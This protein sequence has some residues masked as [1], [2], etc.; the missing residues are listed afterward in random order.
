MREKIG[1]VIAQITG[2]SVDEIMEGSEL[3]SLAGWDSFSHINI[4]L[5]IEEE[6][7]L[8]LD[9]EDLLKMNSFTSIIETVESKIQS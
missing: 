6:F 7:S 2:H 3:G 5:K 4:I 8:S 1:Q 9:I